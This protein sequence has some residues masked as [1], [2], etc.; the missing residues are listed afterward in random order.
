MA[1]ATQTWRER[2]GN[3]F[4][5]SN[6]VESPVNKEPQKFYALSVELTFKMQAFADPIARLLSIIFDKDKARDF[7]TVSRKAD[8]AGDGMKGFNEFITE[9][10][11]PEL[12]KIRTQQKSDAVSFLMKSFFGREGKELLSEIII[13][14]MR[15]LFPPKGQ[16]N[17]PPADFAKET[18]LP[19]F[20]ECL[21]GVAKANFGA[22]GPLLLAAGIDAQ[23]LA[24]KAQRAV[25]EVT[26]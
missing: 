3:T 26:K 23:T 14:S 11:S 5:C 12:V 10:Q 20:V 2:V 15:D 13:N 18:D 9:S 19:P 17:P 21:I 16:Q 25:Q 7:G 1:E 22:F 8:A 6:F 4:I 24:D